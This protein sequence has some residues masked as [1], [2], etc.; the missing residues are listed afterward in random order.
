MGYQLLDGP[1]TQDRISV[2]TS[3]VAELKVGS[4]ALSERQVIT[5]QP[6]DGSIW[7]YFGDGSTPSA[8]TVIA[9]G[10][11]HFK[12]AKESYEAGEKQQI[13]I[14]AKT[15]TVSVSFSERA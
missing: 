6:L 5:I 12:M 13:W 15:G 14:V 11:E 9:K 1:S 10:F 3:A 4:S 7:V 2:T 8:A